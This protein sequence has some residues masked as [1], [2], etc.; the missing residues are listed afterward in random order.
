VVILETPLSDWT[1]LALLNH[2]SATGRRLLEY[3]IQKIASAKNTVTTEAGWGGGLPGSACTT[4]DPRSAVLQDFSQIFSALNSQ[5]HPKFAIWKDHATACTWWE[6]S[7]D[8]HYPWHAHR[9]LS[10]SRNIQTQFPS[11]GYPIQMSRAGTHRLTRF[12][13]APVQSSLGSQPSLFIT[14]HRIHL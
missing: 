14:I 1:R 8:I 9:P 11:P 7:D 13:I 6:N 2:K 10:L 3:R 4:I 5:T 12:S